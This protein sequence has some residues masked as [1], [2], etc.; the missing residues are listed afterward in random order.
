[1]DADGGHDIMSVNLGPLTPE[2]IGRELQA[3]DSSATVQVLRQ[4]VADPSKNPRLSL[5]LLLA[6]VIALVMIALLV[7][8]VMTPSTKRVVRMRRY[9]PAEGDAPKPTDVEPGRVGKPTRGPSKLLLAVTSPLATVGVLLAALLLT[10][11]GTSSETYCARTCH[12]SATVNAAAKYG[13]ARC[14]SC[15]EQQPVLGVVSNVSSRINMLVDRSLGTRPDAAGAPVQSDRCLS[16]HADVI[17]KIVSSPSGIRVSHREFSKAGEPCTQC[18][19]E[20]GHTKRAF[21]LTM[22]ACIGC[23]DGTTASTACPT[24]HTKDPAETRFAR[25]SKETLGG[26]GVEYPAVRAAKRDCSGCH[27]QERDCDTCH[28]IRM[29]HSPEFKEGGHAVA[30][31]FERKLMC[32]RCHDPQECGSPCHQGWDYRTGFGGHGGGSWK[33]QHKASAWDSGCVCHSGRTDRTYP[34]CL[35][36][37]AKDHSLLPVQP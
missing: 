23:H 10:Y 16:C 21:T 3:L 6:V 35:R 20:A 36:C 9:T 7:L 33:Q 28:R 37:H 14:V 32:F 19:P 13:H 22:S 12:R 11:V 29:P 34:L 5:L 25:A 31:A 17:R 1:M 4:L 18:H 30:A 26:G 24:C 27:D 15:H 8:I 2:A